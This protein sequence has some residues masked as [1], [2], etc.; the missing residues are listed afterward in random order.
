M[1]VT[2]H[3]KGGIAISSDSDGVVRTWD[4]STGVCN[5]S[6]QSLAEG[7][8]QGDVKLINRRLIFVSCVNNEI[9]IWDV[10]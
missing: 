1:S 6:F 2:L 7:P 9:H 5:A 3:T 4:I 8:E 10:E